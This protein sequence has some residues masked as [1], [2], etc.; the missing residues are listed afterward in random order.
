[1]RWQVIFGLVLISVILI[2]CKPTAVEPEQP[3]AVED[4]TGAVV[5]GSGVAKP[6]TPVNGDAADGAAII[7]IYA[8]V[9]D[10]FEVTIKAGERVKWVNTDRIAYKV[11]GDKQDSFESE[12]FASGGSYSRVY[13]TPGT[14]TYYI[15]GGKAGKVIVE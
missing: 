8:T 5:P 4:G 14:Y 3:A 6:E 11:L 9:P 15:I 10:P 2:G 13:D 7:Q 12:P 1:M